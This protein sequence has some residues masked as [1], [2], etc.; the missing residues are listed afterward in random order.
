MSRELSSAG[1]TPSAPCA[2]ARIV[3]PADRRLI[4]RVRHVRV[5]PALISEGRVEGNVIP[6]G[7]PPPPPAQ[8]VTASASKSAAPAGDS[9]VDRVRNFVRKL[10]PSGS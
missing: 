1:F 2:S 9:F 6:A 5:R 3:T 10:W 8:A 4:V 7:D